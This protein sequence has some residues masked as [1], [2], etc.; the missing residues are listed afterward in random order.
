LS[1]GRTRELVCGSCG[2]GVIVRTEP[3]RCPMCREAD[4]RPIRRRFASRRFALD[5]ELVAVA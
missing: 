3:P 1:A 4:W 2:Y 5:D